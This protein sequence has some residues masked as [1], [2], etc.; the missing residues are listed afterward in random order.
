MEKEYLTGQDVKVGEKYFFVDT[1]FYFI[2]VPPPT[3]KKRTVYRKIGNDYSTKEKGD[4]AEVERHIAFASKDQAI[5]YAIK[6]LKEYNKYIN[7]EIT[8]ALGLLHKELI[9][10]KN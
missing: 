3:I 5:K 6:E 10:K 8:K 9:C 7:E 4:G 2:D 1:D